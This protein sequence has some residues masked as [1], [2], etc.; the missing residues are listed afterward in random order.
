MKRAVPVA[1]AA[2][3]LFSGRGQ[4]P[5]DRPA[6]TMTIP[7]IIDRNTFP[8]FRLQRPVQ[9]VASQ[10]IGP[11]ARAAGT[12]SDNKIVPGRASMKRLNLPVL[13]NFPARS[14]PPILRL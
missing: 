5:Y 11:A 1:G 14:R 10:P 4:K 8:V 12:M 3:L 7:T 6:A 9:S 2:L 13:G